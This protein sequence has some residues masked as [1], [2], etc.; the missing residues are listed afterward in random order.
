VTNLHTVDSARLP[1]APSLRSAPSPLRPLLP[2]LCGRSITLRNRIYSAPAYRLTD[3]RILIWQASDHCSPAGELHCKLGGSFLSL[4]ADNLFVLEPRLQG[5][6]SFVPSQACTTL[7]EHALAKVLDLIESLA[8][9]SIA[10]EEFHRIEPRSSHD[11]AAE[12]ALLRIGFV[13][14]DQKLQPDVRGWVRAPSSLWNSLDLSRAPAVPSQ[15][16]RSVP[17]MLS[18]RLGCCHLPLSEVRE[19]RGGD[20]LRVTP[21]A[22]CHG[23]VF[24]QLIHAGSRFGWTARMAGDQLI[25]QTQM[26]S[27][28][29]TTSST[30]TAT[31][32]S[33][34]RP[35]HRDA[36]FLSSVE[37]EL[38]FELGSTRMT[39]AEIG[40][41]RTGHAMHLGARLHEQPVRI[42]ASGR[43]IARG[44]LAAVGDELVVVVTQ[45][46]GLPDI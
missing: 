32:T 13:L 31:E 19:L 15:R 37:C 42:L 3:G 5:F 21:R 8:G 10:C 34:S 44:E 1:A 33:A 27:M 6:E 46:T 20:A 25:L 12:G 41:L 30:Q 17:L 28:M 14:L 23:E 16:C 38:T 4:A 45:T 43:Q 29:D 11:D 22:A 35:R 24:V 39:L 9:Q 40:K 18:V 36:D 26:D 2:Q 7:V